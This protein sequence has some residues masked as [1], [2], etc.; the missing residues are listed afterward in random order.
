MD[1]ARPVGAGPA[2]PALPPTST[3]AA[4]LSACS[5]RSAGWPGRAT[6]STTSSRRWPPRPPD[7]RRSD[8]GSTGRIRGARLAPVPSLRALGRAGRGPLA[9]RR[10][11]HLAAGP[12]VHGLRRRPPR[13]GEAAALRLTVRSSFRPCSSRTRRGSAPPAG[14]PR[15]SRCSAPGTTQPGASSVERSHGRRDDR[16]EHRAAEVEAR[17]S[18]RASGRRRSAAGRGG[19]C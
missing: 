6:A 12:M 18:G 8:E 11:Q 4:T 16:L 7:R 9:P 19:R 15:A 5:S 17:R 10:G 1:G 3:R 2:A 14:G 13:P